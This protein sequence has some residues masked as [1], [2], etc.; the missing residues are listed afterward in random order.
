MFVIVKIFVVG[1]QRV[2]VQD[3]RKTQGSEYQKNIKAILQQV[4]KESGAK[5]SLKSYRIDEL[6]TKLPN[7]IKKLVEKNIS[8][9]EQ[10]EIDKLGAPC[11]LTHDQR[12]QV[13]LMEVCQRVLTLENK[14]LGKVL[15]GYSNEVK[16]KMAVLSIPYRIHRLFPTTG[17]NGINKEIES[18]K[19]ADHVKAKEVSE[20]Y[21]QAW[22]TVMGKGIELG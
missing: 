9:R 10:E 8:I 2:V 15:I 21:A 20:K 1:K 19:T 14:D 16:G 11:D 4:R 6:K 12:W 18:L 22:E 7:G 3:F 5:E 17:L 13:E